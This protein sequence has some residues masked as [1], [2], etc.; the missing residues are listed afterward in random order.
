MRFIECNLV[1]EGIDLGCG[2]G[3]VG[4]LLI[5]YGKL[6]DLDGLDLNAFNKDNVV[7]AGYSNFCSADL[8]SIPLETDRFDYAISICV[9]EH[10]EKM[11][12]AF[13]EVRRVLRNGGNF[14]FTTPSPNY[15][16]SH[17]GYRIRKALGLSRSA[18]D[19]ARRRDLISLHA[20]IYS[21][22]DWREIL[23]SSGFKNIR[24]STFFSE[25]QSI[26][27]DVLNWQTFFPWLYSCGKMQVLGFRFPLWK[28]FS[29]WTVAHVVAL[30]TR[31]N[32]GRGKHTH[33]L[34][35]AT[36]Q[37]EIIR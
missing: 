31:P 28:R 27:Y 9:F 30:L 8:S 26:W 37:K 4:G 16:T 19:F 35:Q 1:G 7:A 21:D 25:K 5:K 34:I 3:V 2:S 11:F 6:D 33:L 23:E 13:S 12:E 32:A 14:I 36:V 24:I 22:Q 18:V 15:A 17:L 29:S 10:V 20:H